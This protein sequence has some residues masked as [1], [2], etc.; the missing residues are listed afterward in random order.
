MNL[1]SLITF[2]GQEAGTS[3]VEFAVIAPVLVIVLLG[4]I[5]GWSFASQRLNINVAVKAAS[6][7]YLEGGSN[8]ATARE[9]ALSAWQNPPDDADV[10]TQRTCTC[11]GTSVSCSSTCSSGSSTPVTTVVIDATGTWSAPYN[12]GLPFTDGSLAG[13]AVVRVR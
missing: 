5:D 10:T 4:I 2:R 12:P 11:S 13:R 6:N 7:Y 3:G 1:R 8:D 9:I